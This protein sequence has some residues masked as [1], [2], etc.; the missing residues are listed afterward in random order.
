[1]RPVIVHGAPPTPASVVGSLK[2]AAVTLTWS[3]PGNNN[4]TVTNYTVQRAADARFTTSVLTL[5]APITAATATTLT[6][7]AAPVGTTSYY[8][9]RSESVSGYSTWSSPF[10]VTVPVPPVTK[11]TATYTPKV[12]G[13]AAKISVSWVNGTPA[14]TSVKVERALVDASSWTTL[15]ST[16]KA[17]PYTDTT[18]VNGSTYYYRVTGVVGTASSTPTLIQVKVGPTGGVSL[19]Q[20]SLPSVP[21]ETVTTARAGTA[22]TLTAVVRA[23]SVAGLSYTVQVSRTLDFGVVTTLT[24][25][26]AALT[27]RTSVARRTTYYVRVRANGLAG[28]SGWSAVSRVVTP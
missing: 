12:G 6:D 16:S 5:P 7:P 4:P 1:M 3:Q 2:G 25:T 18:F 11:L 17:S 24:P 14:Y 13:T 27:A 26:P 21:S 8:R 23:G 10:S 20:V 28:S 22:D 15:S 9:V 19:Q